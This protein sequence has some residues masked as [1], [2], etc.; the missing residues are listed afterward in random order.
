MNDGWVKSIDEERDI[1][2]LISKDLKISQQSLKS[3]YKAN[4]MLGIIKRGVPY[5]S[6]EVISEL[7]RL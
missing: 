5:K 7:Y 6:A 4:L 3:N 2:V 1:G